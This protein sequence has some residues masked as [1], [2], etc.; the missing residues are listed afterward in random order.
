ME[1]GDHDALEIIK[2]NLAGCVERQSSIETR[3]RLLMTRLEQSKQSDESKRLD[4]VAA[5]AERA[6]ER[7]S[8]ILTSAYPKLARQLAQSFA[9]LREC[10]QT[11]AMA[12]SQLARAKRLTVDSADPRRFP[13]TA[14]NGMPI[15]I[16]ALYEV[17]KLPGESVDT[18]DH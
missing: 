4:E 17:V 1:T 8:K 7:G 9:E 11:I 6:R 3:I 2:K 15:G 13:V 18:P 10:E 14:P 12:N 5:T 16:A